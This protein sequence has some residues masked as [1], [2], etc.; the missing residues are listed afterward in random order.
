MESDRLWG[1]EPHFESRQGQE[2]FLLSTV[3]RPAL[4]Q[5]EPPIQRVPGVLFVREEGP[6]G[7]ADNTPTSNADVKNSGAT[8]L[9]HR[10]SWHGD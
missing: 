9:L 2:T 8:S 1:R 10:R 4:G 3:S 6:R 7:E 5:M